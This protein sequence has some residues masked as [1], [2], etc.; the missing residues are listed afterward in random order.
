MISIVYITFRENCMFNW[1]I[2]SLNIQS[3]DDI[4]KILQIIIV[5]G[6]LNDDNSISRREYFSNLINNEY[7]FIHVKPKPTKWQGEYKLTNENYF[8][9][10]NTR[11]TGACYTKHPYIAFV[12]DLGVLGP[13]WLNSIIEGSKHNKIYCGAYT[14]LNS[15]IVDKGIM[16]SGDSTGG[17]DSRLGLYKN[18]I[19]IC[20]GSHMYG[21]SFS[22][23]LCYYFEVNG[24]NEMCDGLSAEDYDLGIRL[25]RSGKT[26]YYN[27]NMFIY[28]SNV[29]FG[30]DR[31]RRCVRLDPVLTI[32]EYNKLLN[33]LN[34]KPIG[35]ST[36]YSH[37]MLSYSFSGPYRVNPEFSIE[38]YNR[39][40]L[41]F[42]MNPNDVFI[43]PDPNYVH[44]FTNK[45]I[46]NGFIS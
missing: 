7:D 4:K 33:T 11:N 45:P 42:K 38:D 28:E 12:D 36:N 19:S 17:V 13:L 39:N 2:D 40:I 43:K 5:D 6:Y 27:K 25:E 1:F 15:M 41:H 3:T 31:E 22:M 14:K 8:A 29:S 16:I 46:N 9:A 21:S 37:F 20:P 30:S 23:P 44:F 35:N 32:T 26:L 34:I 10:A 18:D 24:Q